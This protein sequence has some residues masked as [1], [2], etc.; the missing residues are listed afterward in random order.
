[1]PPWQPPVPVTVVPKRSRSFLAALATG[2]GLVVLGTFM[3]WATVTSVFGTITK[4]GIE[5]PDGVF[6]LLLGGA[7]ICIGLGANSHRHVP[8]GLRIVGIIVGTLTGLLTIGEASSVSTHIASVGS[9]AYAT[10]AVGGGIY[11]LVVGAVIA[12][13]GALAAGW[14][15]P[16]DGQR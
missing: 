5:T 2:G 9:N 13:F 15:K 16:G 3:P 14:D 4:S 10:A 7:L 8:K 1:M 12:F 11:I 6:L